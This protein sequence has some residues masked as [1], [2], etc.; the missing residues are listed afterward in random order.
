MHDFTKLRRKKYTQKIDEI[1][2]VQ[3][4]LTPVNN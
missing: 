3:N 2:H 4:A 1:E